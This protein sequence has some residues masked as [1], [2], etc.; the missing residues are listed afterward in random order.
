MLTVHRAGDRF[1]TRF[2]WLD[3][4]HSFSFGEHFDPERMGFRSLRVINDDVIAG[5]GG[6]PT[7]GHRDMEIITYPLVGAVAHR[8]STGGEGVIRHGEVQR[9]TAGSGIRHSEFNASKTE[10][11]RLLQIWLEPAQA[12]LEPGYEQR[13]IPV[14]DR[15]DRL[16]LV[17]DPQGREGA[18]RIN[19]DARLWAGQLAAGVATAVDIAAGRHA[20]VQVA[21][22]RVTVNGVELREGDG[23]AVSDE[24]RLSIA[25]QEDSEILVFDL[26]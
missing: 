8:D 12:G 5:G 13:S 25:V 23:L 3:S 15:R 16:H 6:F 18:V 9:M 11:L 24:R 21:T 4:W 14:G 7:H 20:W 1:H 22:G 2:G 17:A 26:A 10:R 19:Q